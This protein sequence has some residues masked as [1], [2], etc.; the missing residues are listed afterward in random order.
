MAGR[1]IVKTLKMPPQLTF[2]QTRDEAQKSGQHQPQWAVKKLAV[3]F[4]QFAVNANNTMWCGRK[5][6]VEPVGWSVGGCWHIID[7]CLGLS[8]PLWVLCLHNV[9]LTRERSPLVSQSPVITQWTREA[10]SSGEKS[11]AQEVI[12]SSANKW[13]WVTWERKLNN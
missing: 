12:Y 11:S 5:K 9:Y 4:S 6:E 2:C 13:H 10:W 7:N 8:S 3:I 1:V